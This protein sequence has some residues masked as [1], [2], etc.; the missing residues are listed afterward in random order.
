MDY[1][2]STRSSGAASYMIYWNEELEA[3]F[4]SYVILVDDYPIDLWHYE[5]LQIR[6]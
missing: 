6:P 2:G 4:V 1:F 5:N 3:V